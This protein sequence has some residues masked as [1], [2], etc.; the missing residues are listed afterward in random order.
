MST[1]FQIL[2][3]IKRDKVLVGCD[4]IKWKPFTKP[5][6]TDAGSEAAGGRGRRTQTRSFH[7]LFN[8]SSLHVKKV[9][10][11]E[12]SPDS[13]ELIKPTLGELNQKM[14]EVEREPREENRR[15]ESLQ[16][17]S[18]SEMLLYPHPISKAQ[19]HQ[20]TAV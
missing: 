14:K 1:E 15:V 19:S 12:Y 5:T 16:T 18:S 11:P 13:W 2:G 3:L 17:P 8:A 7:T 6:A 4:A 10:N 9:K 20:Q